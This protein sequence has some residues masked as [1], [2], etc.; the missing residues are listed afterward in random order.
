MAS[1]SLWDGGN[2]KLSINGSAFF[3]VSSSFFLHNGYNS[4]INTGNTNPLAGEWAWTG[5]NEGTMNGSWGQTQIDLSSLVGPGD[6]M[7]LRFDL[8]VDGCNGA[9]GW[10]VDN[11]EV[12]VTASSQRRSGGRIAP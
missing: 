11:I 9:E 3:R 6:T 12:I 5:T 4:R 2:L 10:Y 8:G 1:E 7:S